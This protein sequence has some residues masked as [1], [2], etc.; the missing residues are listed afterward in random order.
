MGWLT[1]R[2]GTIF[3]SG[4]VYRGGV[5][6]SVDDL[7]ETA[8]AGLPIPRPSY[9]FLEASSR[10]ERGI[11]LEEE[12]WGVVGEDPDL[13]ELVDELSSLSLVSEVSMV[14]LGRGCWATT[15]KRSGCGRNLAAAAALLAT[16][17]GGDI[18]SEGGGVI[19]TAGDVTARLAR[20]EFPLPPRLHEVA[21]SDLE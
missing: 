17:G 21:E 20:T 8:D 11:S 12:E 14:T 3:K 19:L 15:L 4:S 10:G 9:N 5:T 13:E 6:S 7:F 2:W 1:S 16:G 18:R